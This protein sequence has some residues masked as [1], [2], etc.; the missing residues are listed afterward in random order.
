MVVKVNLV[1]LL[2]KVLNGMQVVRIIIIMELVHMQEKLVQ[3]Q[4]HLR[5]LYRLLIPNLMEQLQIVILI[6]K[7]L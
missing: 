4:Q 2:I 6:V 5:E 7:L 3:Q 1:L